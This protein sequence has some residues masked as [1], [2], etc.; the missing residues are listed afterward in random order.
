MPI[1]V[2]ACLTV[3]LTECLNRRHEP[4]EAPALPRPNEMLPTG[5]F[6]GVHVRFAALHPVG[7]VLNERFVPT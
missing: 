7:S 3:C 4:A 6:D 5:A 1:R 2:P